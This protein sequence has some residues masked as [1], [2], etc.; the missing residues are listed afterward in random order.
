MR[1]PA[2][3]TDRSDDIVTANILLAADTRNDDDTA[4]PRE[5]LSRLQFLTDTSYDL[6]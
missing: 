6:R 5:V 3:Y 1:H 2:S 4:A